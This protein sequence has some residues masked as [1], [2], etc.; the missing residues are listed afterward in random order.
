[1]ATGISALGGLTP[2][3]IK[4]LLASVQD[5][6]ELQDIEAQQAIADKLRTPTKH[7][8]QMA[9]NVYVP[10]I[11]GS[12]AGVGEAYFGKKL[13]AKATEERKKLYAQQLPHRNAYFEA[14]LGLPPG[15]LT[16]A[17][18][19]PTP[20]ATPPPQPPAANPQYPNPPQDF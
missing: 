9:G 5:P 18:T 8:G 16:N 17:G 20:G 4:A 2:E 1:M 14:M 10:D 3:E 7:P 12:L 19:P 15:T 6:A 11:A 13:D